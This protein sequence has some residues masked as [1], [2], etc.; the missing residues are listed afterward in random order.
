MKVFAGRMPHA[1]TLLVTLVFI[2]PSENRIGS[3]VDERNGGAMP[4]END[5][6][7]A[8]AEELAGGGGS[9]LTDLEKF[10]ESPAKS[11]INNTPNL[12][13]GK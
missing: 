12:S 8:V 9:L 1:P 2:F 10:R 11:G 3:G 5:G 6:F 4:F 13:W 7:P